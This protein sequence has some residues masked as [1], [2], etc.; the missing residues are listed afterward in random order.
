M[1]NELDGFEEE[2]S[3]EDVKLLPSAGG[4]SPA[5]AGK[6]PIVLIPYDVQEAM[7]GH[8]LSA[9]SQEVGGVLIGR[10]NEGDP[11]VVTVEVALP[12]REAQASAVHITFT[13]DSWEHWHRL[14]DEQ[15]AGRVI[16]GWY[17]S[18]PNHGVFLSAHDTFIQ[19]NF[20]SAPWQVAVVID[21][22]RNEVG[23]FGWGGGEIVRMPHDHIAPPLQLF[24][25]TDEALTTARADAG[26]T[27]ARS[28][29]WWLGWG[30]AIALFIIVVMQTASLGRLSR[31][32]D[33]REDVQTLRRGVSALQGE[34][35]TLRAE[36]GALRQG[37][38]VAQATPGE[39]VVWKEGDS[40]EKIAED[41][42]GRRELGEV[43]RAINT[44]ASE[45]GR[46]PAAGDA[47]WV[48]ARE[49]LMPPPKPATS[50]QPGP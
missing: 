13:A 49:A 17:H 10:V 1:S 36:V 21:P 11:T 48:P 20:F 3:V 9:P 16:V 12:A 29:A 46:R 15:Y 27:S 2:P 31:V 35:A 24:R 45:R 18:H 23:C 14:L 19:E 34:V 47:V 26:A 22:V 42:Y 38:A 39:W 33:I 41:A 44:L 40:F 6:Q 4:K 28:R 43:L 32:R 7:W 8:A 37:P 50:A 25:P 5:A 30:V